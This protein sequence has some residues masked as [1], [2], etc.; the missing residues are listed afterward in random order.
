MNIT[1]V[2]IDIYIF[3]ILKNHFG[4]QNL[5]GL[6]QLSVLPSP[7]NHDFH[8]VKSSNTYISGGVMFG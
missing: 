3:F 8:M 2:P 1:L 4:K 5:F 7:S 6:F